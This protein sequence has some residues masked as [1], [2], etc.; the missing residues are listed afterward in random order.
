MTFYEGFKSGRQFE[1]MV[2][3]LSEALVSTLI[4]KSNVPLKSVSFAF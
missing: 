2:T 1:A 3:E 4:S